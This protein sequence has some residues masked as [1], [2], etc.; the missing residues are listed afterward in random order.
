MKFKKINAITYSDEQLR[1]KLIDYK[2]SKKEEKFELA[3][4]DRDMCWICHDT[5]FM[6][7]ISTVSLGC[8]CKACAHISCAAKWFIPKLTYT[9]TG[10]IFRERLDCYFTC[11]CPTCN[12]FI[13]NEIV[14][15]FVSLVSEAYM[16]FNVSIEKGVSV[17]AERIKRIDM[18]LLVQKITI[19]K[20]ILF[21]IRA[22]MQKIVKLPKENGN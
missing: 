10:N 20:K 16:S 22:I 18:H 2:L 17:C 21:F 9:L 4:D 19:A 5:T 14:T 6:G 7:K 3:S 1:K 13:S 11:T 8:D 12:K 15:I